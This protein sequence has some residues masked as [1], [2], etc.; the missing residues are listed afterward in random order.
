MSIWSRKI[1]G[2]RR[3]DGRSCSNRPAVFGDLRAAICGGKSENENDNL[4]QIIQAKIDNKAKYSYERC[5]EEMYKNRPYGLYKF[6]YIEDLDKINEIDLYN[7]CISTARNLAVLFRQENYL[8]HLDE[9]LK[10]QQVKKWK[11]MVKFDHFFFI[12][13][14]IKLT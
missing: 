14:D 13:I 6:G 4:K 12:F 7:D 5:I 9:E 8:E 11:E 3:N 10:I 2:R 1:E